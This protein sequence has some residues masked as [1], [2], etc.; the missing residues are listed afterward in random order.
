MEEKSRVVEELTE[1]NKMLKETLESGGEVFDLYDQMCRKCEGLRKI[2]DGISSQ[3]KEC[4][5]ELNKLT[6]RE[7]NPNFYIM[8]IKC[9]FIRMISIF[10]F[11]DGEFIFLVKCFLGNIQFNI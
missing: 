7:E 2:N 8:N 3:L 11:K 4:I 9:F 6:G 1:R 10:T 5:E